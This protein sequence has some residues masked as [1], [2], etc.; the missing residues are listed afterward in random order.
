VGLG[1]VLTMLR[2][3]SVQTPVSFASLQG[4]GQPLAA[5]VRF[6]VDA[7]AYPIAFLLLVVLLRL[8]LRRLWLAD[9]LGSVLLGALLGTG[10]VTTGDDLVVRLYLIMNAWALLWLLRRF[11]L[12]AVVVAIETEFILVS[13]TPGP[14]DSWYA[15]WSLLPWVLV[16]GVAAWAL[17]VIV[18]AQR[19][20]SMESATS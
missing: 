17:W 14:W 7:V 11:G 8:L 15:G 1:W 9:A 18:S 20:A 12:L 16:V 19:P 2:P 4:G 13:Q 3:E 6:S 5:L 10:A